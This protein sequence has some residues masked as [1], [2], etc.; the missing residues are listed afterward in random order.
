VAHQRPGAPGLRGVH[1]AHRHAA[2]ISVA[3]PATDEEL[4]PTIDDLAALEHARTLSGGT[5]I[6]TFDATTNPTG[7][8]VEAL[9]ASSPSTT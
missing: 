5:E 2:T 8:Q 4:T 1:P 9:I 7:D 3:D 6:G